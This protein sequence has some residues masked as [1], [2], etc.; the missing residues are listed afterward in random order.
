MRKQRTNRIRNSQ[1]LY[2][3]A[4]SLIGMAVFYFVPALISLGYAFTDSRGGF[5]WFRN[6]IDVL[7]S[8]TFRLA[9]RNSLLF[10]ITS[11]PLNMCIAYVLKYSNIEAAR[12]L[13]KVLFNRILNRTMNGL[14]HEY[15]NN[16]TIPALSFTG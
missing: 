14:T 6:F 13:Y 16:K 8:A 9:A 2:F 10:I 5:I 1:I 12:W 3:L 4:P 11:V 15:S 7:S